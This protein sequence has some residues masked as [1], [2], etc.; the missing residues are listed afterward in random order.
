MGVGKGD[1]GD[2][3]GLAAG[4]LSGVG[5]G[6]FVGKAVA[7]GETVGFGDA[8][9]LGDAVGFGVSLGFGV[10]LGVAASVGFADA[11]VGFADTGAALG[12]GVG[13]VAGVALGGG[14]AETAPPEL[15]PEVLRFSVMVAPFSM[16]DVIRSG[17]TSALRSSTT[18]VLSGYEPKR[19]AEIE[20]VA[21]DC[22][23][24]APIVTPL[25]SI[26]NRD[27]FSTRNAFAEPDG[28]DQRNVTAILSPSSCT[29][30]W[31]SPC[32]TLCVSAASGDAVKRRSA[33]AVETLVATEFRGTRGIGASA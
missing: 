31:R 23:V 17:A 22:L 14:V 19:T 5:A 1:A 29:V 3:V 12:A 6:V 15:V 21:I 4:E 32:L 30:T 7:L 27:G 8:V 33:S 13:V 11:A 20:R 18:R 28:F 9:G 16:A 25:M 24:A 26:A 10:E 2:F